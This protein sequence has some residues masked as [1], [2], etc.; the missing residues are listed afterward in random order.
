MGGVSERRGRGPAAQV[1]AVARFVLP[2]PRRRAHDG[3]GNE[4]AQEIHAFG[5]A[6]LAR[7]RGGGRTKRSEEHTSELQSP[8]HLVCRL[9]LEKKKKGA[10][11]GFVGTVQQER[12]ARVRTHRRQRRAF[13]LKS[14]CV[15]AR[16]SRPS[17]TSR[18]S[19]IL[20][21]APRC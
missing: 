5:P 19:H 12:D 8:V 7:R 18:W 4:P 11:R 10:H 1:A 9:L 21:R 3:H 13:V 2:P 20:V 16:I 15:M 6:C 17:V 14:G